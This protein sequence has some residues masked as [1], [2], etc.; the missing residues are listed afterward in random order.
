MEWILSFAITAA[1]VGVYVLF[2]ILTKNR[3]KKYKCD[4]CGSRMIFLHRLK[5]QLKDG[6]TVDLYKCS[7]CGAQKMMPVGG[8][9]RTR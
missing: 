6:E 5:N 9:G 3:Q 7:N 2:S 4:V 1:F 8:A